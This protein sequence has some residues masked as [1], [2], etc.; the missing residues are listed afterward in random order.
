MQAN[1]DLVCQIREFLHQAL[2]RAHDEFEMCDIVG[3]VFPDHQELSLRV[4]VGLAVQTV[5][6]IEHEIF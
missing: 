6:A 4:I 2:R 5:A 3:I 1:A